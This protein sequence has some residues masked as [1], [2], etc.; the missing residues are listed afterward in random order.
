MIHSTY[1]VMT[2]YCVQCYRGIEKLGDITVGDGSER[3]TSGVTL[4]RRWILRGNMFV[5]G[6]AQYFASSSIN[7]AVCNVMGAHD[8]L[9][10]CSFLS[11]RQATVCLKRKKSDIR[12]RDNRLDK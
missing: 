9:R 7:V 4:K 1:R 2:H 8:K 11:Y 10:R 6:H 5:G 3:F 12:G